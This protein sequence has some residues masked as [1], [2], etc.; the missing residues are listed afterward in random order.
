M[1]RNLGNYAINRE[2]ESYNCSI[3]CEDL[4]ITTKINAINALDQ[5]EKINATIRNFEKQLE[6]EKIMQMHAAGGKLGQ[7]KEII[8]N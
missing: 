5:V 3:T 2:K 4:E 6:Q 7:Q 8:N 1:N